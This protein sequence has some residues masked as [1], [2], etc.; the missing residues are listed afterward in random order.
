MKNE[1]FFYGWGI[2]AVAVVCLALMW[3]LPVTSFSL[4]MKP[5]SQDLGFER[6]AFAL[7]IS[8]VSLTAMFM[9]PLVGRWMEQKSAQTV[10]G[11]S[12]V[13][14]ALGLTGY[15]FSTSLPMFYACALLIGVSL[16]GASFMAF[17][18][19]IKNWFTEKQGL[20]MSIALAGTGL[21]GMV[22][23]PIINKFII[24]YGW[25]VTYQCLAAL[26][27]I[28]VLPLV[29][30]FVRKRPQD[31]GLL[32][33]GHGNAQKQGAA[34]AAGL[35]L[36]LAEAKTY[37]MFWVFMASMAAIGFAGGALL[38]QAP[39]Y[40][41]DQLSPTKAAAAVSAYLGIA[42]LGKIFLG[43]VFD[44]KG[45]KAGIW[46][47]CGALTLAT[48][49]LIG[50]RTELFYFAFIMLHGIGT[51]TGTVTPAILT[52]RTFGAKNYGQIYGMTNLFTQG[53]MALG[54]PF[55]AFIYDTAGSYVYAWYICLLVG[56]CTILGLLYSVDQSQKTHASQS[57]GNI[58]P[59]TEGV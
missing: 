7:C 49:P 48:I 34:A 29:L 59:Q 4:F 56:I 15:S 44:S 26:I 28:V 57:I 2:V 55:V 51:C 25:R 38:L 9:S 17:T 47:S 43:A 11:L 58:Q 35:N 21:G 14:I 31:M 42:V 53:G 18:I 24:E 16:N 27:I 12:T 19:I 52:S 45:S 54:S 22:M 50:I 1:K 36:T 3:T 23:S 20:A 39:A 5:I 13:G 6:S 33:Y 32:P 10:V 41:S 40:I 8:I 46:I 37:P 30:L